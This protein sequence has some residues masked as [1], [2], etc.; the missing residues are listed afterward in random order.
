MKAYR[1][2]LPDDVVLDVAPVRFPPPPDY[3]LRFVVAACGEHRKRLLLLF[4]PERHHSGVQRHAREN[5]LIDEKESCI[6]GGSCGGMADGDVEAKMW[7]IGGVSYSFGAVPRELLERFL[8]LLRQ[9]LEARYAAVQVGLDDYSSFDPHRG[10][11]FMHW[12][13]QVGGSLEET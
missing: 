3:L 2:T 4:G 8:P 10:D 5:G 1:L 9:R 11:V 6:G 12:L 13:E 7:N